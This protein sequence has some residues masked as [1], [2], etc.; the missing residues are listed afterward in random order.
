MIQI[1]PPNARLP[2]SPPGD[3]FLPAGPGSIWLPLAVAPF[4]PVRIRTCGELIYDPRCSFTNCTINT[5][6]G[7]F[8]Y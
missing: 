2:C 5:P 1:P 6:G 4:S 8:G 7:S 3:H